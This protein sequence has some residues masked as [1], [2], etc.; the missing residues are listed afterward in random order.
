MEVSPQPLRDDHGAVIFCSHW[1]MRLSFYLPHFIFRRLD[2]VSLSVDWL[3]LRLYLTLSTVMHS[4]LTYFQTNLNILPRL[5]RLPLVCSEGKSVDG[6]SQSGIGGCVSR[7]LEL[8]GILSTPTYTYQ[9][10]TYLPYNFW[11]RLSL[12]CL[13]G[14]PGDSLHYSD[15]EGSTIRIMLL[16]VIWG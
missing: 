3:A 15:S 12:V 13:E 7:N 5:S 2:P 9:T 10:S 1:E 6:K 14:E 8:P 4:T 11:L 16:S